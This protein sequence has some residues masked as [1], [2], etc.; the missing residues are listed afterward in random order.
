[1]RTAAG[2]GHDV[3]GAEMIDF[4][5][6]ERAA[7]TKEPFRY[8][9]AADILA[10]ADLAAARA[11][12][13]DI[14]G[15]GVYLSDEL[16]Y[17]PAFGRLIDEIRTPRMRRLMSEKLGLDLE[18]KPLMITTRGHC[19]PRDGRIHTDSKDKIATALLYLNE[20]WQDKGSTQTGGRLRLLRGPDDMEDM[21]AEVPPDGG[22]LVAFRR[23]DCSWHGHYP[24]EGPRRYLMFNWLSS[25]A[26]FAKNVARHKLSS[27]FKGFLSYVT[28]TRGEGGASLR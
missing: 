11:D 16:R 17:G 3:K 19:H 9:V 5:A 26:A 10:P 13:P 15:T 23:S 20:R 6:I 1:M 2:S 18:G 8:F 25:P 7:V 14:A 27:H 24:F 22:T 28:S 4:D 21:L 12:F